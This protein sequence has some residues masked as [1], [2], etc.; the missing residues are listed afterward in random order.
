MLS[1]LTD[2]GV[3]ICATASEKIRKGVMVFCCI[4]KVITKPD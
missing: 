1:K 3:T 2:F 4:I